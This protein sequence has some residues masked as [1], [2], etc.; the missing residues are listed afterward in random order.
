MRWGWCW[1][2]WA[3]FSAAAGLGKTPFMMPILRAFMELPQSQAV[4]QAIAAF[5][6]HFFPLC[7]SENSGDPHERR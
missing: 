6:G 2:L 7:P 5:A 3:D 1:W 4:L